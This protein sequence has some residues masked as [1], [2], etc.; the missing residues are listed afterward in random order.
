VISG[1]RIGVVMVVSFIVGVKDR[2]KVQTFRNK[3]C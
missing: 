3:C 2:P 1:S